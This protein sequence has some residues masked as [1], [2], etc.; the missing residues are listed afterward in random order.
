MVT[1]N[2]QF[3]LCKE[4]RMSGSVVWKVHL[5]GQGGKPVVKSDDLRDEAILCKIS[6]MNENVT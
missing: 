6:S 2:H 1:S 4:A 3:V 5:V